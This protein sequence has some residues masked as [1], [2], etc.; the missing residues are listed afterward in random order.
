MAFKFEKLWDL[1]S[2]RGISKDELRKQ[3]GASQTTIVSMG[4]NKSVSLDVIDRI[5]QVLQCNPFEVME[6]IPNSQWQ[7]DTVQ[8]KH[9]EIYYINFLDDNKALRPAVIIQNDSMT[10]EEPSV[11]VIP[12][13][14]VQPKFSSQ[15][16]TIIA[17]TEENGLKTNC[18]ARINNMCR[19]QKFQLVNKIG[20][21]NSSDMENIRKGINEYLGWT[22]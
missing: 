20:E 9:G 1:L 16:T 7:T 8:P 3:I 19:V 15:N 21:L 18:Y 10:L 22:S 2:M 17:A 14:T 12:L 4:K 5:C 6:Y 13:S 11:M